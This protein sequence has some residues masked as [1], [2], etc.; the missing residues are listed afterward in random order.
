MDAIKAAGR[1]EAVAQRLEGAGGPSGL[2]GKPERMDIAG[3]A[4]ELRG[5]A[6]E[7]RGTA[8]EPNPLRE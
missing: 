2:S 1:I 8:A 4:K 6:K 7:L 3:A 5:I